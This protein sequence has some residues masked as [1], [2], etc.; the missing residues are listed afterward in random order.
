[1]Y[2]RGREALIND[3]VGNVYRW[4]NCAETAAF[5]TDPFSCFTKYDGKSFRFVGLGL[6][7]FGDCFFLLLLSFASIL[8]AHVKF[9]PSLQWKHSSPI[10][11]LVRFMLCVCG[12]PLFEQGHQNLLQFRNP[13]G[14]FLAPGELFLFVLLLKE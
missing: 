3:G 8:F 13:V 9:R 11:L 10:P 1:M 4:D 12:Q 2:Y 7:G 6:L 5:S 14:S